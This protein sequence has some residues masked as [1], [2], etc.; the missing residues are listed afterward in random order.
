MCFCTIHFCW[1]IVLFQKHCLFFDYFRWT[2][3][4]D[5]TNIKNWIIAKNDIFAI[6]NENM[7]TIQKQH[8]FKIRWKSLLIYF[9]FVR[10]RNFLFTLSF[11]TNKKNRIDANCENC[12]WNIDCWFSFF[13]IV[14]NENEKK[15]VDCE[16]FCDCD[17]DFIV[18]ETL[19]VET[20]FF[21]RFLIFFFSIDTF[22]LINQTFRCFLRFFSISIFFSF[23]NFC[24]L[25]IVVF[26]SRQNQFVMLHKFRCLI[27]FVYQNRYTYSQF[28]FHTI[29]YWIIF[30]N[31]A[32][33][34]FDLS[35]IRRL[36]R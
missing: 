24:F 34:H 7:I 18:N 29:F 27:F 17:F 1:Q 20:I 28:H 13:F 35:K 3:T 30:C 26:F 32:T 2:I 21:L 31:I 8:N 15:F 10:E 23:D 4:N 36:K 25:R 9:E 16:F 19:N 11:I 14:K 5:F 33:K 6:S 22:L 12:D